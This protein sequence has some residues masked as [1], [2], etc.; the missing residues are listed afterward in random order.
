MDLLGCGGMG[1]VFS[2]FHAESGGTFALK[3]ISR[4]ESAGLE[5]FYEEIAALEQLDHPGVVAIHDY[6]VEQGEPWYTMPLLRAPTLRELLV[7][8][9]ASRGA[10]HERS[11]A[12]LLSSCAGLLEVLNY[13]HSRGVVHGDVKPENIF[14]TR[15]DLPI[16]T[17]FGLALAFDRPRERLLLAPRGAGSA[18]YMAPEQIRGELLDARADLYAVGCILYESLTGVQPSARDTLEGTLLAHLNYIPPPVDTLRP[19]IPP[20]LGALVNRLL[21]KSAENRPG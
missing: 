11:I 5:C 1:R 8:N 4:L 16:L 9:C 21:A 6:G 10:F 2:A 17:G 14:A 12:K 7:A 18:A 13:V 19:D 15:D 3:T 20:A